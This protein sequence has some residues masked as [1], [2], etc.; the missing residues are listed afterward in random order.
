MYQIK[1]SRIKSFIPEATLVQLPISDIKVLIGHHT[2]NILGKADLH[3]KVFLNKFI[4]LHF[5]VP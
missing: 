3:C 5:N 1:L 4:I 2:K